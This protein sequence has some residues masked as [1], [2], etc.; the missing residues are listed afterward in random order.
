MLAKDSE[1]AAATPHYEEGEV[2][3]KNIVQEGGGITASAHDKNQ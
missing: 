3:R 1:L 2:P